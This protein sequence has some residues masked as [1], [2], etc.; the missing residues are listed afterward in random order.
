MRCIL[1]YDDF[2]F[3][4]EVNCLG[5]VQE[6]VYEFPSILVNLFSIPCYKTSPVFTDTHWCNQ[7]RS[8][9]KSNNARI[10]MHGTYHTQEEYKHYDY[11]TAV[12]KLKLG[13]NI[14]HAAK[15]DFVKVFRGPHWGLCLESANAL[16]DLG[17]THIYSHQSYAD[18]NAQISSRAIV[19]I[20]HWNLKDEF[21]T[22]EKQP[23]ENSIII[24]HG[25]TH[26]VCGNGIDETSQRLRDFINKYNPKFLGVDEYAND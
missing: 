2:H 11:Q 16:C 21:G 22:F 1:E 8:L 23:T 9:I 10:A 7:V 15:L 4:P 14:F 3:N 13:E 5:I 20:Y 17:Y 25:H 26:N 24:A 19:P 6:L 12:D 18:L